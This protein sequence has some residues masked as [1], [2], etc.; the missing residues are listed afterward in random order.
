MVN[1]KLNFTLMMLAFC[2][3]SINFQIPLIRA[4]GHLKQACAIVN[5]K[6]GLD[7][8]V[9]DTIVKATDE[10]IDYWTVG[11]ATTQHYSSTMYREVLHMLQ[12]IG[13]VIHPWHGMPLTPWILPDSQ[14]SKW[15]F[16]VIKFLLSN[17]SALFNHKAP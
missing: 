8:T 14:W 15:A 4:F 11:V 6:Y 16:C 1:H 9:G 7:K 5:M 13:N 12:N 17:S 2:V 10:V 3:I